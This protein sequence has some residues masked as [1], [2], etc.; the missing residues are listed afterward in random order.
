MAESFEREIHEMQAF[1][2]DVVAAGDG[3]QED[4]SQSLAGFSLPP[5]DGGKAAW[6][7]LL[8][9]FVFEAL[10]WGY[11]YIP[12]FHRFD[13]LLITPIGFPLSFGVFQDFY[14]QLPQWNERYVSVI[15]AFASGISYLAAPIAIPF[16]NRFCKYRRHMILFGC[17]SALALRVRGKLRKQDIRQNFSPRPRGLAKVSAST[18]RQPGFAP[19]Q[20]EYRF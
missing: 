10:L 4:Q 5:Y 8:A 9:A 18:R 17:K 7:L 12:L 3:A 14:A 15:G 2:E 1:T 19:R 16:T 11:S 20:N 6:S 13:D